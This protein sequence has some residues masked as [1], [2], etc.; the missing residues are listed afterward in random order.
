VAIFDC[1]K[2]PAR[3]YKAMHHG[4]PGDVAA[5][6]D[7]SIFIDAHG[8]QIEL[9]RVRPEGGKKMGAGEFARSAGLSITSAS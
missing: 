9:L 3:R 1:R 2:H 6:T 4:K 8:G 7:T 5:I